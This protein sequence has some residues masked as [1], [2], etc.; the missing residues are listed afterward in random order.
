MEENQAEEGNKGGGRGEKREGR[1]REGG[2]GR[3][4]RGRAK[5]EG[6]KF[7]SY[8]VTFYFTLKCH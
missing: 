3:G 2:G 7:H 6:G 1:G 5:G 4:G 8:C